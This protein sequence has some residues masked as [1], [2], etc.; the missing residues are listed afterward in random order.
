MEIVPEPNIVSD[1]SQ[2]PEHM[3][4]PQLKQIKHNIIQMHRNVLHD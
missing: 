2:W 3:I 1:D 4:E